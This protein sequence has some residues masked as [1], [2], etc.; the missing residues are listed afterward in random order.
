M[1]RLPVYDS[2]TTRSEL[3]A[4]LGLGL[5]AVPL[6][7]LAACDSLRFVRE[8]ECIAE[9]LVRPAAAMIGQAGHHPTNLALTNVSTL[10]TN[11]T[12][13]GG[14][15]PNRAPVAAPM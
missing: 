8:R 7:G 6:I 12:G 13:A 15:T 2:K 1:K 4:F 11:A 10:Q 9:A 3:L 14:Q 5:A